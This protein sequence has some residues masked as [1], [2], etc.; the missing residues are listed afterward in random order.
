MEFNLNDIFNNAFGF[1]PKDRFNVKDEVDI[2]HPPAAPSD[3]VLPPAITQRDNGYS[4]LGQPYYANDYLG[5]EMFLPV[6][7]EGF[8]VPFAVVNIVAKKTVISTAMPER[9]GAVKELVSV[10]DF[11]INI[12][13]LMIEDENLYPEFQIKQLHDLFLVNGNLTLRSVLTDIFLKGEFEHKVIIKE[14]KWP[15]IAAVQN[16]KPFEIDCESDMIFTL[17]ID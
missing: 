15:A 5:R 2:M 16:V 14:V 12:K 8:V 3:F 9:G 1:T 11:I 10:D 6:V 7:L 13:G 17:E 4:Q